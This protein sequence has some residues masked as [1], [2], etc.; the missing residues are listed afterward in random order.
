M[1]RVM[2]VAYAFGKV[3]FYTMKSDAIDGV[4][5]RLPYQRVEHGDTFRDVA[6]QLLHTYFGLSS[7]DVSLGHPRS[8]HGCFQ[9]PVQI[10]AVLPH[11]REGNKSSVLPPSISSEVG[12]FK[13]LPMEV[14]TLQRKPLPSPFLTPVECN[15]PF[16][17][18]LEDL[19]AC[20]LFKRYC[21]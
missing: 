1:N 20:Y 12:G 19:E 5:E 21:A 16:R 6:I 3:L 11:L 9:Y 8:H 13:W 7:Q 10:L 2:I 14:I 15:L 17:I 4:K 18:T